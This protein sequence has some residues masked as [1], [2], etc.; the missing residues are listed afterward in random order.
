[1]NRRLGDYIVSVTVLANASYINLGI[2][3]VKQKN[4]KNVLFELLCLNLIC[5]DFL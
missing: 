5:N 2:V 1:M 3:S 4:I